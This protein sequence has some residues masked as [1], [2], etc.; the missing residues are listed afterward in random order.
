ML[1]FSAIITDLISVWCCEENMNDI[2]EKNKALNPQLIIH[3]EAKLITLLRQCLT[4]DSS[5]K[6]H[7][8]TWES[9]LFFLLLVFW[10]NP[11]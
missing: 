5:I 11:R 2:K 3:Q 10:V 4:E 1:S 6:N 8:K 9:K 7:E